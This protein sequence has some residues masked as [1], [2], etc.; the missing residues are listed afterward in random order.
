MGAKQCCFKGKEIVSFNFTGK[1]LINLSTTVCFLSKNQSK[2]ESRM[3]M[4]FSLQSLTIFLEFVTAI[5][6]GKDHPYV[7]IQIEI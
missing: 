5:C 6:T 2:I 3:R 4:E 7:E 1:L